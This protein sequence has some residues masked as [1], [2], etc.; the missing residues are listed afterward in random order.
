MMRSREARRLVVKTALGTVVLCAV[1]VALGWQLWPWLVWRLD[2]GRDIE[3]R[4]LG[5]ERRLGEG[6]ALIPPPVAWETVRFGPLAIALPAER[7]VWAS[8]SDRYEDCTLTLDGYTVSLTLYSRAGA[9]RMCGD[10]TRLFT[11]ASTD[12]SPFAA[13]ATN[14][15]V[16]EMGRLRLE[17]DP[18]DLRELRA[19]RFVISGVPS[20]RV[21]WSQRPGWVEL[22]PTQG[23]M[24][25]DVMLVDRG[26]PL[27]RLEEVLGG[28][29]FDE[30]RA[31]QEHI[32]ADRAAIRARF[33]A[34][35]AA[36]R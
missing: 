24:C 9:P 28:L 14:E 32:K 21:F 13:R 10:E 15:A 6:V 8:C 12:A 7:V 36:R 4:G 17:D 29:A 23:A 26:R 20:Y 2:V 16:L 30:R 22:R 27:G 18:L 25:A 3:R 33:P 1:V 5:W 35:R 11:L 34:P 19:E 31:T